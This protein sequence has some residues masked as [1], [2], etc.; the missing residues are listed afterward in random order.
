MRVY[1]NF[2]IQNNR[3]ECSGNYRNENYNKK[4]VGVV[5]EKDCFQGILIKEGIIGA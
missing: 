4:E 1:Q 2:G 3:G 5:L